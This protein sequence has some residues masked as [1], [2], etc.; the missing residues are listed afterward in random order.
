MSRK[1]LTNVE[2][3][4]FVNRLIE[5]C[6]SEQPAFIARLLNVSYQAAKNYLNGR[7]P[8][9]KVLIALSNQTPYSIHWLLTGQ[10]EKLLL[11]HLTKDAPLLSD[12]ITTLIK[13]ECRKNVGE[14]LNHSKANAQEKV[15]VL[16]S[17]DIKDEKALENTDTL[18]T[19]RQ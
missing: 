19:E 16:R 9:A 6:G 12:Q 15:I 18:P 17:G 5:A 2:S 10:G 1:K 8:E 7:M 3:S 14:M 4:A 13:D 11:S